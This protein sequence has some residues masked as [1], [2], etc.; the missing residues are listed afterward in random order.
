MTRSAA[1]ATSRP[2]SGSRA[3]RP[4]SAGC[5]TGW[6][7]TC[8]R[9]SRPRSSRSCSLIDDTRDARVGWYSSLDPGGVPAR[10]G[11]RRRVLRAD[12]RPPRAEPGAEPDD[13]DLCALHRLSALRADLVATAHLPLPG[14]ARHRRRVGGRRVAALGDLA[15][16]LAALDRGGAA[17]GRQH[18]RPAGRGHDLRARR[19]EPSPGLPGR[20]PPRAARLLDPPGGAR[21]R[22][23]ARRPRGGA[24]RAARPARPLPRRRPPDRAPD[25]PRL[26]GDPDGALG[27]H[28]LVPAAPAQPARHRLLVGPAEERARQHGHDRRHGGLD[29]GQLPRG[30]AGEGRSATGGR[31]R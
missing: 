22:G 1:C 3:S 18:R 8:I 19:P 4:G 23:V 10:L 25:D 2:S 14:R 17:D 31:S 21:A 20:R 7:C 11:A 12:R 15:Q 29:R 16:A 28:V 5:S 27:V 24:D 26:L 6:T 30:R 13:P 9:W